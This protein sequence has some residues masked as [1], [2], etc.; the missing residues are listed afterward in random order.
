ME[1]VQFFGERQTFPLPILFFS[2]DGMDVYQIYSPMS[3]GKRPK[4]GKKSPSEGK[5]GEKGKVLMKIEKTGQKEAIFIWPGKALPVSSGE[6]FSR[7]A[8]TL[9]LST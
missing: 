6:S 9:F 3:H 1:K 8:N 4:R 5:E 2:G 7:Q